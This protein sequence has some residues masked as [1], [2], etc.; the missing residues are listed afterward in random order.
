MGS[1]WLNIETGHHKKVDKSGRIWPMC[2]GRI[3][4]SDVSA[5]CFDAL[6]SDEDAPDPIEDEHHAIFECS[7]YATTR[8]IFSSFFPQPCIH[9]QPVSEPA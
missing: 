6:D 8:Q 5:D 9:C 3:T 7:D 1:H 2:V 4:I